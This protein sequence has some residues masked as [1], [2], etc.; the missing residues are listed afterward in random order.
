MKRVNP[1]RCFSSSKMSSRSLRFETLEDRRLMAVGVKVKKFARFLV[2]ITI[3]FLIFTVVFFAYASYYM[4]RLFDRKPSTPQDQI[5]LSWASQIDD[6][7]IEYRLNDFRERDRKFACITINN[8]T[9]TVDDIEKNLKD[10]NVDEL[11]LNDVTMTV[12]GFVALLDNP[13]LESISIVDNNFRIRGLQNSNTYA[14]QTILNEENP[15]RLVRNSIQQ[16]LLK[17]YADNL[18]QTYPTTPP[19]EIWYLW[20]EWYREWVQE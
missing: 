10:L 16:Y 11:E 15:Q 17:K 3:C 2:K 4:G 6:G 1:S 13:Y 18:E 8:T 19:D 12:S 7:E 9:L 20:Y 5:F 14:Q